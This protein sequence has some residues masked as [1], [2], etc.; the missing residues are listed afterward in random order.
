MKEDLGLKMGTPEEQEWNTIKKNQEQ[1][2]RAS[3]I[4]IMVANVI[5]ELAEKEI[6]KEKEKFKNLK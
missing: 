3:K 4:N 2:L 6:A 1:T 5:F